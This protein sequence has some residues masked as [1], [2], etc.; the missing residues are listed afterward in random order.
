[1]KTSQTQSSVKMLLSWVIMRSRPVASPQWSTQVRITLKNTQIKPIETAKDLRFKGQEQNITKMIR[2]VLLKH[3]RCDSACH[4][5]TRKNIIISTGIEYL[6]GPIKN[7]Q[8][9][10]YMCTQVTFSTDPMS[11]SFI[12][13]NNPPILFQDVLLGFELY[14]ITHNQK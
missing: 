10:F 12:Q 9:K 5:L 8:T 2:N 4:A 6:K 3:E 7:N 1:M 14:L 13:A 11:N